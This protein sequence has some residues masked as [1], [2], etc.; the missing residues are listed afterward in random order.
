MDIHTRFCEEAFD[1]KGTPV[2]F[3]LKYAADYNFGYDVVDALGREDPD[4]EAVCWCSPRGEARTLTFADISRLSSRTAGALAA[5]GVQKGDRVLVILRR[6]L[7]YWY[8][9]PA[10]HKLG[11]VMVPATH[12]LT[13][14]DIAYRLQTAGIRFAVCSPEGETAGQLLAQPGLKRIFTFRRDIPGT[15]NLTREAEKASSTFERVPTLANEP[16]IVYFTSGT[17]GCPKGVVHSHLYSLAHIQTARHWQ[18]VEA[19]GRHLTVAETGWGKASWGKI[20]GQWI[21]GCAVMVYDFASFSPSSLLGVMARFRVT[22]FC[23]PPTVYRFLARCDASA[24]DLSSLKS[25]TTAGEAMSPDVHLKIKRLTGLEIREGFG[26]TESVLMVANLDCAHPG[27]MGRPTPLY[28]VRIQLEDGRFAEG[29][30]EGEIVVVPH[31]RRHG[32]FMGYCGRDELYGE[33]WKDGVYHTGD[34]AWRDSEGLFWYVGRKD[35]L[36]KTRGFRVSPFEVEQVL[37][38]HPA[39]LE[40]AVV[41]E[42]DAKRGHAVVAFVR[43]AEGWEATSRLAVEIRLF[44]NAGLAAY[45]HIS[46]L[47]FVVELPKTISGKVKRVQLRSKV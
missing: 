16:M 38:R 37:G 45:K 8:T 12:M 41:G 19:G 29:D 27:S 3:D 2:R 20:Y 30:E 5:H 15:V 10:L 40:C 28:D 46:R 4:A 23:A 25:L 17:T 26:Q 9:A 11:A 6:N 18:R 43:L 44:A 42:L 24:C 22:S 14:E 32:V 39:V 33:V 31:G 35:D 47:E 7:E 34:I 1:A 36:I 13:D 21:C